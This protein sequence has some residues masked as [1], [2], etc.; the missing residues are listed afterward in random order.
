MF[1]FN[2]QTVQGEMGINMDTS[3]GECAYAYITFY[4]S[5]GANK[6]TQSLANSKK[7]HEL[8]PQS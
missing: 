6:G 3:V 8:C 2:L 1:I 7:D 5:C 4:L